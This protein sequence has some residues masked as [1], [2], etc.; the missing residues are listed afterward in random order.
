M[1]DPL[2]G[3]THWQSQQELESTKRRSKKSKSKNK[4]RKGGKSLDSGQAG[5]KESSS[6]NS[7]GLSAPTG[8]G[9]VKNGE[10]TSPNDSDR[11]FPCLPGIDDL[12]PLKDLQAKK[13]ADNLSNGV[14]AVCS[15]DRRLDEGDCGD[16]KSAEEL[17]DS[18]SPVDSPV[19]H[20]ESY[21]LMRLFKSKLF[22]MHIAI[23][24]L[25]TQ[26]DPDVQTYLG[27]KLFVSVQCQSL[28]LWIVCGGFSWRCCYVNSWIP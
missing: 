25:Y 18:S 28:C 2:V 23:Q 24:Y 8:A 15:T 11:C 26:K 27:K 3:L 17:T 12:A 1:D 6:Q 19:P 13:K 22:D 14:A 21:W 16:E 4:D 7:T 10:E 9:A 20:L 5:D